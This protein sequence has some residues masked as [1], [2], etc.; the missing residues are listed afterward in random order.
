MVLGVVAEIAVFAAMSRISARYSL[1]H[2]LVVSFAAAVVRF[3]LIGWGASSLLLTVS[4]QLM[5]GLTFPVFTMPPR[6]PR[7]TA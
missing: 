7:S 3:V 4:A 6:L 5:H 1:R 2:L